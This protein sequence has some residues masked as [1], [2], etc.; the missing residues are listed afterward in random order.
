MTHPICD[1]CYPALLVSISV[2]PRYVPEGSEARGGF[3]GGGGLVNCLALQQNKSGLSSRRTTCLFDSQGPIGVISGLTF[4]FDRAG[5]GRGG[6]LKRVEGMGVEK[7]VSTLSQG[8][9]RQSRLIPRR[10][11]PAGLDLTE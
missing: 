4:I 7:R 1:S 2:H 6:P 11:S 8:P 5:G 3:P 9:A 10:D